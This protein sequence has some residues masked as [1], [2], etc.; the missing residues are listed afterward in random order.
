MALDFSKLSTGQ[1]VDTVLKPR[2]IFSA[3][4]N[5]KPNKFHYPRD[6]QSQV[7]SKWF[8]RKRRTQPGYKNEYW[9]R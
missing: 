2:E 5:K 7:W 4:P 8:D 6:V 1:T 3:L 9:W